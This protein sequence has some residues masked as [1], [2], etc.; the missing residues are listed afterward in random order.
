MLKLVPLILLFACNGTAPQGPVRIAPADG[1][2]NVGAFAPLVLFGTVDFP[3]NAPVPNPFSVVD[4]TDGGSVPGRVERLDGA[5]TFVADA[6][7]QPGHSYAWTIRQPVDEVRRPS[8]VLPEQVLGTTLFHA[9]NRLAPLAATVP[10]TG[11]LCIVTSRPFLDSEISRFTFSI[12]G[13]EAELASFRALPADQLESAPLML[14]DEGLGGLCAL[15][16]G[17]EVAPG[18]LVRIGVGDDTALTETSNVTATALVQALRK[19]TP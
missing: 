12:D 9:D 4:L 6:P 15:L 5:L 7:W 2:S 19:E 1:Q 18:A 13:A 14:D 11:E 17:I 10:P 3:E 16:S 8:I